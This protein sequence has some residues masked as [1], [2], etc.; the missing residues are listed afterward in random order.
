MSKV[1]CI[2]CKQ[3]FPYSGSAGHCG[4]CHNTFIGLGS[5]DAHRVGAHGTPERRCEITD[6]HWTDKNGYWHIG[7]RGVTWWEPEAA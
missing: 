7:K 1:T 6:K 5:F 2:R 4:G 3:N